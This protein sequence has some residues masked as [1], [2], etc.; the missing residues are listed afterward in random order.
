VTS[1]S[2]RMWVD[3]Q[4][5][6]AWVDEYYVGRTLRRVTTLELLLRGGQSLDMERVRFIKRRFSI[7]DASLDPAYTQAQIVPAH[8]GTPTR[9]LNVVVFYV[10]TLRADV[11]NDPQLMPHLARFRRQSWNFARAYATGS[12]TLRSL[13]GILSGNYFL[14]KTHPGDLLRLS[15][16]KKVRSRLVISYAAHDFLATLLPGF[17]FEETDIIQDVADGEEVW[18]Y[19]AHRPTAHEVV[20]RG[21]DFIRKPQADPFLL[22]LFHFDQHGW[23]ELDEAFIR[24]RAE[25]LQVDE[26]GRLAFRYRVLAR[27][28]DEEF[29]RF[30]AELEA[31]PRASDTAVLFLSDHGEALGR[32]GFWVHSVFLWENLIRVPLVL[33]IPGQVPQEITRPVSLL[34]VTPTLAALWGGASGVYHGQDLRTVGAGEPRRFPLLLRGGQFDSLDRIGVLDEAGGEKFVLRVRAGYPELHD[35]TS[36]AAEQ[37]NLASVRP[38]RV[39]HLIQ[40]LARTPVFPRSELDFGHAQRL[41]ELS[42][43]APLERDIHAAAHQ[44]HGFE[45]IDSRA[46]NTLVQDESAIAREKVSGSLPFSSDR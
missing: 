14:D 4:L 17:Q 39:Q 11:A 22:W 40:F 44:S 7:T 3:A 36:D 37:V 38:S 20:E 25:A 13:P 9:P 41:I 5:S 24:D 27:S 6:H 29:G 46:T 26:E 16:A 18:G 2:L 12:D 19:G 1:S 10:D 8:P 32:G 42:E 43:M 23:R 45:S 35:L 34:D 21:L 33:R 31:S 28:I 15:K 30:L